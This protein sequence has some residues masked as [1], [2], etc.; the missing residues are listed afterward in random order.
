MNF[1][2]DRFQ[3][4]NNTEATFTELS[5]YC[6]NVDEGAF[7]KRIDN[8]WSIAENLQHL[9]TSTKMTN[10]ALRVPKFALRLLYGKPN[11]PSRTYEELIAKYNSKL[12]AGAKASGRY[13]PKDQEINK[14]KDELLVNWNA[15]AANY[16]SRIKYYWDEESL[17]QYIVPHPMLGK[18]TIRE[19]M[20][21]TIYHSKHHLKAIRQ[22]NRE[23]IEIAAA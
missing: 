17:D 5:S 21:F 6:S 1:L 4:V 3:I 20:Y 10:L 16:L 23:A 22:R 12:E 8:K 18:I 13:I 11:R 19:L 2:L 9:I 7:F 14:G 15:A